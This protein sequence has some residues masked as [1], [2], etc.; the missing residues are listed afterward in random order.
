MKQ[1]NTQLKE[2]SAIVLAAGESSRMGFPKLSLRYNENEIF[3]EHIVEEFG[4]FGCREI[5]IVVNNQGKKY[6]IENDIQFPEN[7]KIVVNTHTNWH[8]FYSLKVGAK[9]LSKECSTFIHNV[10]N[11]FVNVKV[12][13]SLVSYSAKGD[14]VNPSYNEKGGHPFLLS[15]NIIND[16]RSSQEDK[17]HLKEFLN[18]YSREKVQVNDEKILVNINTKEEY[19]MYFSF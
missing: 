5:I 16:I 19:E 18:Q 2:F 7:I 10:D 15:Q 12:L 6:L 14:Y 9:S 17:L 4:E 1:N 13:E 8:R 11:P 3:I